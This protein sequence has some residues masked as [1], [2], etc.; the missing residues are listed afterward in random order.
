MRVRLLASWLDRRAGSATWMRAFAARLAGRG[1]RVEILCL[2]PKDTPPP[3]GVA[4]ADLH[5]L[6]P[7]RLSL[8]GLW[9]FDHLRAF[10]AARRRIAALGLAAPDL[11]IASEHSLIAAH[12]RLFPSVPLIY[13]P[14]AA[15]PRVGEE[16]A[17]FFDDPLARFV[18]VRLYDRAQRLALAKADAV[19][20]FAEP[21][22]RE[23]LAAF[24]GTRPRRAIVVPPAVE[25]PDEASPPA[26]IPPVRLLSLG[27]L[28]PDKRVD[29]LIEVVSHL[30]ADARWSLDVVGDG[31]E[32]ARLEKMAADRGLADR[33]TFHGRVDDVA[34]FYRAC[35]LFLFPSRAESLGLVQLEA[36]AHARPVLAFDPDAPGVRLLGGRLVE[37]GLTGWLAR[38]DEDFLRI[39]HLLVANPSPLRPTGRAARRL[40]ERRHAWS[41]HLDRWEALFGE[42][43]GSGASD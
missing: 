28:V 3:D 18:N 35:D 12:R 7:P 4:K 42:L 39:L 24:P 15:R 36:M 40:V 8:P 31:P 17:A 20:R 37:H 13:L 41:H 19:V 10:V 16:M 14:H 38:D 11:V 43:L 22:M 25:I 30:P 9:R 33:V 29:L 21:A 2:G 23:M 5:V 26:G 34:G 27:R 1:H 6:S 32:R